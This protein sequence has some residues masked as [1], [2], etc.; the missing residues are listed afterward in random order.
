MSVTLSRVVGFRALHRFFRP[1]WSE[2]RNRAA[3]GPLTDAPGHAHDYQCVVTVAGPTDA[4]RGMV[5]DLV[6]LDG[7]L[8]DEVVAMFD[9]RHL[10]L[11]IPEFAYGRTLPT[12]EAIAAHVFP[13]IAAR[14]PAGVALKRVRIL[15]DPTLYADCTGLP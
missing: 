15:E 3:F 2:A 1:D 6:E 10:N 5:M 7:V 13:R 11:D 8:R 4:S 14:L 9:G 12:C